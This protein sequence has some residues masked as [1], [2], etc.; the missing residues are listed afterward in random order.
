MKLAEAMPERHPHKPQVPLAQQL[1]IYNQRQITTCPC[2][3]YPQVT[4]CTR[5]LA[6]A[7]GRTL[8][9]SSAF[10]PP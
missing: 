9:T 7:L 2:M 5:Q 4:Q 6:V 3:A 1:V 10:L 8:R